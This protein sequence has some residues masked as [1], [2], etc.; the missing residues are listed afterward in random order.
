ME[1]RN[2][3]TEE[4]KGR[5]SFSETTRTV[6]CKINVHL[7]CK[8]VVCNGDLHLI[9]S[10][11]RQLQLV[12]Q[13]G[14]VLKDFDPVPVVRPQVADD[15]GADGLHY[16]NRLVPLHLPFDHGFVVAGAGVLHREQGRLTN[17]TV[18]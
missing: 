8:S 12:D 13:Q 5:F 6:Y 2:F 10:L 1:L 18:N 3:C 15:P 9:D 16:R 7:S 11:V 14:T 4:I 17:R